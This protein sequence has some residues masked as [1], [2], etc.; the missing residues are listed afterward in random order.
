MDPITLHVYDHTGRHITALPYESLSWSDSISDEGS[1]TAT[2][3]DTPI[4]H[5]LDLSR[6]LLEYGTIWAAKQGDSI[7]HAGWL[8]DWKISDDGKSVS[9]DAGGGWTIWTKR[10]VL[11]HN[12]WNT[13]KDGTV[14]IDE[15]NPPGAWILTI[16]GTLRDICRGLIAESMKFGDLPYTLPAI[17]GG[18]SNTRTYNCCDMAT[19][20]DQLGDIADLEDGPEIRFDPHETGTGL[21]FAL[22]VGTPEIVDQEHRWNA[23]APMQRVTLAGVDA[24]GDGIC[25]QSWAVGGKNDDSVLVAR[26]VSGKLAGLGWPEALQTANTSHTSVSI[27]ETLKSYTTADVMSGD[28]PQLTIGVKCGIEHDVHVG[29][30]ID[31]RIPTDT[32]ASRLLAQ[33]ARHRDASDTGILRRKV[34]DVSGSTDTDWLTLQTRIRS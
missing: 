4:L 27:L 19:V 16:T 5:H 6:I 15:K 12:L 23:N 3:P 25:S 28:E 7:L 10:L 9:I 21:A 24:S 29:D 30:H 14:L 20:S 26:T 18:T 11:N 8:T 1:L 2:I 34:T 17:Q 31:L 32:L 22:S 33:S 13:W